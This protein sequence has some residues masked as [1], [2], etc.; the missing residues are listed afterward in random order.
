MKSQLSLFDS[1]GELM[2]THITYPVMLRSLFSFSL[3]FFFISVVLVGLCTY[4]RFPVHSYVQCPISKHFWQRTCCLLA[5]LGV[6]TWTNDF[7]KVMPDD[8]SGICCFS[9]ISLSAWIVKNSLINHACFGWCFLK[10]S[11][12]IGVLS[13]DSK[14]GCWLCTS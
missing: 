2:E 7:R 3:S 5:S 9:C 4:L 8:K 13:T 1:S 14:H 11:T 6:R 12:K 10:H